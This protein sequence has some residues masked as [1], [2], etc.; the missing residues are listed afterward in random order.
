MKSDLRPDVNGTGPLHASGFLMGNACM[1]LASI[2]WGVNISVTKALI[3]EWMT[4]EGIIVVRLVLGAALF[5]L[6]S[7]F[8][9][10]DRIAPQDWLRLI[11]G[12]FVGLFG[13]IYLFVTSL[14]YG[15]PIDISIIMTLPPMFVILIGVIFQRRRPSLLEYAGV[16]VSFAGALIVILYGKGGVS[17]SDNFLGN[18]LATASAI[19]YALY[20]V[21]LEKPSHTY[22]PVTMLRWVFL[23]SAIPALF[24]IPG[25]QYMPI[26]KTSSIIPWLEISFILVCPTFLAYFLVQPAIK[27]IGSELV[28]LYQYMI[29]V[30][31]SISA[32]MMDIDKLRWI[33]VVAMGVIVIG[34]A[35]TNLGKRKR[36]S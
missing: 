18:L 21:I 35:I 14:R 22:R 30:F 16:F 24:L 34:M 26:F 32:V 5:W 4:A 15:N 31:A 25:M 7:V 36:I 8:V 6:T 10:C 33:Q 29:P 17:G 23:F 9:K 2:F 11:S 19:C 20:L 3:P 1:L 12:G 28:S 13:F 27:R